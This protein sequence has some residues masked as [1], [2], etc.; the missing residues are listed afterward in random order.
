M[1]IEDGDLA[2]HLNFDVT[3]ISMFEYC[4][5]NVKEQAKVNISNNINKSNRTIILL[6]HHSFLEVNGITNIDNNHAHG[7]ICYVVLYSGL[8]FSGNASF[9]SNVNSRTGNIRGSVIQIGYNS[10]LH[11]NATVTFE[12]NTGCN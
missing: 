4:I 9:V 3:A 5:L 11:T 7:S 6:R 1:S 8:T 10:F 2:M 12:N